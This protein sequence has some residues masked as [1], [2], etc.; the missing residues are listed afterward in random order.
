MPSLI[1]GT[2]KALVLPSLCFA[3]TG[4]WTF[5]PGC[6]QISRPGGMCCTVNSLQAPPG[7]GGWGRSRIWGPGLLSQQIQ[8]LSQQTLAPGGG[9]LL[10]SAFQ[11]G[12]CSLLSDPPSCLALWPLLAG[13]LPPGITALKP[14]S[15]L[16]HS[17]A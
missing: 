3:C 7:G 2:R 16:G 17:Q 14:A 6:L 4:M 15:L 10:L 9:R 13:S 5:L 1:T 12:A 11:P 8:G